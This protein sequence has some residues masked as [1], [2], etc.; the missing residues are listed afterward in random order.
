MQINFQK[1]NA[2]AYVCIC[3][4]VYR[5][6]SLVIII[7]IFFPSFHRVSSSFF[8]IKFYIVFWS[9]AFFLSRIL[10]NGFEI[11]PRWNSLVLYYGYFVVFFSL[12][13]FIRF[14]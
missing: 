9:F 13:S 11:R 1:T 5:T 12:D 7:H 3:R 8:V 6:V 4:A 10:I 14:S 2:F